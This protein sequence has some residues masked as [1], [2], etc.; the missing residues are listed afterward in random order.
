LLR[1]RAIENQAYVVGVN[2]CGSDPLHIYP[3]CTMVVGPK[4]DVMAQAGDE[5]CLLCAELELAAVKN[6]RR[7]FPVLDDIRDDL[8]PR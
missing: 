1:A 3:G 2:R 5:E 4:G 6:Y 8:L 7:Q